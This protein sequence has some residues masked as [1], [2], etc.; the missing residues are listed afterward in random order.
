MRVQAQTALA[1]RF[2]LIVGLQH[3]MESLELL[4]AEAARDEMRLKT[5]SGTQEKNF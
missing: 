3:L 4:E 2:T 1:V 5:P